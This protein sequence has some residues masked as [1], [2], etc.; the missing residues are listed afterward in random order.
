[1]ADNI[2]VRFVWSPLEGD[3]KERSIKF[4]DHF[5]RIASETR[6]TEWAN[7]DIGVQ[8]EC[9]GF[10][11][12]NRGDYRFA[13]L[14]EEFGLRTIF[15]D[16]DDC[17]PD[18]SVDSIN[19]PNMIEL[20]NDLLSEVAGWDGILGHCLDSDKDTDYATLVLAN[21][22]KYRKD[23]KPPELDVTHIT[24]PSKQQ[25]QSPPTP[26][27]I[28]IDE[29]PAADIAT[30][31][32]PDNEFDDFAPVDKPTSKEE[33]DASYKEDCERFVF[34]TAKAKKRKPFQPICEGL[35]FAPKGE[36]SALAAR[37]HFGKTSITCY[38]VA[39][40]TRQGKKVF[41]VSLDQGWELTSC[42]LRAYNVVDEN[43]FLLDD[44]SLV[45]MEYIAH[46]VRNFGAEIFVA[47]S[48]FHFFCK[49]YPTIFGKVFK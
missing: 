38:E 35:C 32:V 15:M 45:Y 42:Y 29:I 40:A 12:K 17:E 36:H 41:Y 10:L 16:G 6:I 27:S 48:M 2:E 8:I 13:H 49:I 46:R 34:T 21:M 47:D 14:Q 9:S 1:M 5:L 30:T 7:G 3:D 20:D 28:P 19:E 18:F 25:T 37:P 39:E 31:P 44:P 4:R 26:P 33:L 23:G 43:L 22:A 11:V 24:E